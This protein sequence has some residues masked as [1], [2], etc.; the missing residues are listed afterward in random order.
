MKNSFDGRLIGFLG[1]VLSD[2]EQTSPSLATPVGS[3]RLKRDAVIR[4]EKSS[5]VKSIHVKSGAVWLTSTPARGDVLLEKGA[6]FEIAGNWPYLIQ[7][8]EA[9]EMVLLRHADEN[10]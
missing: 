1:S 2:W 9:G 10:P 4:L 7:A 8:L 5:G 6:R 3:V